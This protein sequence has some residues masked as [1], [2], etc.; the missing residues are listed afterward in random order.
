MST[1]EA[2]LNP[3]E[4]QPVPADPVAPAETPIARDVPTA[5]APEQPT[6]SEEIISEVTTISGSETSH[7]D[8][9]MGTE[10]GRFVFIR[11][12]ATPFNYLIQ[13]LSSKKSSQPS[14]SSHS[15]AVRETGLSSHVTH[16][17]LKERGGDQGG[18]TR[19][20]FPWSLFLIV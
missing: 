12:V 8:D 5:E 17:E 3:E 2:P 6:V 9:R 20:Q 1:I 13:N 7:T 14:D 11:I 15:L 18:K 19:K 16:L 4:I 10:R